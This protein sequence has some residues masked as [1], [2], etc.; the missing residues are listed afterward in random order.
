MGLPGTK[1]FGYRSV[2]RPHVYYEYQS[3][4]RFFELTIKAI[5]PL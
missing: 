2:T 5:T 3:F 4:L 1:L